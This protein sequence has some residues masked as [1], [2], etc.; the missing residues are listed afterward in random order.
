MST[1]NESYYNLLGI[2]NNASKEEIKR[3]WRKL[4][5]KYHPDKNNDPVSNEAFNKINEAYNILSNENEKN[6][7]DSKISPQSTCQ[8]D[9]SSHSILSPES[10]FSKKK[11]NNKEVINIDP[12]T[13]LNILSGIN[14]SQQNPNSQSAYTN[15]LFTHILDSSY[16]NKSTESQLSKQNLLSKPPAINKTLEISLL[17]SF[18]GCKISIDITRWIIENDIKLEETENIYITIPKGIDNNEI[19]ILKNKGNIISD[20]NKGDIKVKITI[21]NNTMFERNGIDLIY[22]KTISLKESLCGFSFTIKYL[23]NK[24]FKINNDKGNVIPAKFQKIIPNMGMERDNDK[25]NLIIIFN[26]DYPKK[27]SNEQVKLLEKIL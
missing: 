21:Y 7:Y 20:T 13:L 2:Q 11:Y 15:S 22:N 18:T 26:I 14:N 4:S 1:C 23:D 12:N 3:A 27:I 6:I 8:T 10:I 17:Q 25:G 5:F 19:I 16:F 24:E 9:F